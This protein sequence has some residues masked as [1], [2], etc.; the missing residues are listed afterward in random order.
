MQR[1]K[2]PGKLRPLANMLD[3]LLENVRE[4]LDRLPQLRTVLT[5]AALIVACL[6]TLSM[7]S[8][9]S[10]RVKTVRPPLPAQADPRQMPQFHGETYRD[11]ILYIIEVREWGLTCEA[12]KR[13][14]RQ[15]W[16]DKP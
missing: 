11:A 6:L 7:L 4:L 2:R 13:A 12:D 16:A 8:G 15:L 3:S 10:Q 14:I 1:L 5:M 9:C